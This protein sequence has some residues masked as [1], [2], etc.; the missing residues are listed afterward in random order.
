MSASA[1]VGDRSTEITQPLL[2]DLPSGVPQDALVPLGYRLSPDR[3]GLV[4]VFAPGLPM[5]MAVF[6]RVAGR[7]GVFLVMPILAGLAVWA[8]YGIGRS[9]VGELGGSWR[10]LSPTSPAFVFQLIHAPMSDIAAAAWWTM[11]LVLVWRPGRLAAYHR[12]ARHRRNSDAPQ[13]CAARNR[14]GRRPVDRPAVP[15]RAIPRG[16]TVLGVCCAVN[17]RLFAGRILQWYWYGSPFNSGYGPLAGA[18][19]R[20]GYFWPNLAG[21]AGSILESQGPL[22]LLS[23]VGL[24]ALWRGTRF[25]SERTVLTFCICFAVAV[26]ACYALYMPLD[27]WWSLRFLLPAFPILFILIV[28]GGFAVADRLPITDG[29]LESPS[30]LPP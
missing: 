21:Y 2:D 26:Y 17:R 30:W 7:N 15:H 6:E 3:S 1:L 13:P 20:W 5:V 19:F 12:G 4:P 25:R 28:A 29:V 8:T 10:A 24:I 16:A 22:S 14:S 11:A 18:F 9:L 27:V 23:L